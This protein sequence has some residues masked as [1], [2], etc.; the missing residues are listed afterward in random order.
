[1]FQQ[2]L[3]KVNIDT[4]HRNCIGLK[5]G[6]PL[7][8]LFFS[9]IEISSLREHNIYTDLL[10]EFLKQQHNVYIISPTNKKSNAVI[11]EYNTV[12]VKVSIG[13]I[14]KTNVLK[15]GINTLLIE[16]KLKNAINF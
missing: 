2:K 4:K 9:L 15:K 13:E 8:V 5:G 7:N 6:K 1:M 14:Q 11:K 16:P 12:I 3:N 10:R